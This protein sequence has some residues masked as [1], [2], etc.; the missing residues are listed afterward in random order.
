MQYVPDS[1]DS[2]TTLIPPPHVIQGACS[3]KT[4]AFAR[5]PLSLHRPLWGQRP[6]ELYRTLYALSD[7]HSSDLTGVWIPKR[8][9]ILPR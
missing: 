6:A 8:D 9:S 5:Y 7:S 4:R 2:P 3:V 1:D